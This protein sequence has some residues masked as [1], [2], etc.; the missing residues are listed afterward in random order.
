[1]TG[2]VIPAVISAALS[3]PK[4]VETLG[5]SFF[6]YANLLRHAG[7]N[8][9][10]IRR[11]A[12][13]AADLD[14]AEGRIDTWLSRLV[15][16]GLVHI[17]SPAP[18]FTLRIISWPSSNPNATKTLSNS[19][20]GS[21]VLIESYSKHSNA[22]ALQQAVQ[23]GGLGEGN[24]IDA[25]REILG[26]TAEVELEAILRAHPRARV[27]RILARVR[28]TPPEKIRKSKLAFFRHLIAHDH[29]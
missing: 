28:A 3:L 26:E 6:L 18:F 21:A 1:M 5:K 8:G 11:K 15:A 10:V 17:H 20:I 4:P 12:R 14:V 13:L 16:V 23:D 24:L 19:A 29:P 7:P 2:G 9:T 22:I 27:A 25:A